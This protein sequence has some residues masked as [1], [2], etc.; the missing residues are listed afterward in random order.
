[1]KS[2]YVAATATFALAVAALWVGQR[3]S[4]ERSSAQQPSYSLEEVAK[5]S[6]S[7]DCWMAIGNRVHDLTAY[8]PGHPAAEEVIVEW[9]GRDATLAFET[10]NRGSRHS[11]RAHELLREYEIGLL[12]VR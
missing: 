1:M 12:R 7:T 4:P 11:P 5:H 8:V 9:C 6:E 2:L 10:K 3:S